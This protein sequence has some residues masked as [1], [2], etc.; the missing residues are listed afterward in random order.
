VRKWTPCR[1][2]VAAGAVVV[3]GG[4]GVE[5]SGQDFGH[6]AVGPGIQGVDDRRVPQ[7][8][9]TDVSRDAGAFGNPDDHPVGVATIDGLAGVRSQHQWPFGSVTAGSF[10]NPEYWDGERHRGGLV[11]FPDQV[12]D[13]LA[14]KDFGVVPGRSQPTEG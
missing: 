4:T 11:A 10:E 1:V 12:Q 8:V 7:G 9:W 6:R 3:L 14:A 2:E 5:V 13:S